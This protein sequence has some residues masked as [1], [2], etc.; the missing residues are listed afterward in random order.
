MSAVVRVGRRYV[1]P[2]ER[3]GAGVAAKEGRERPRL[4]IADAAPGPTAGSLTPQMSVSAVGSGA[5]RS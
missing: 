1:P 2:G 4:R 5:R 3:P